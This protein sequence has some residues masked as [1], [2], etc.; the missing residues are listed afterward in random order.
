MS[1]DDFDS[2]DFGSDVD[3]ESEDGSD[4]QVEIEN[5][6]Y[7]AKDSK[8]TGQ[9]K[10]ALSNFDL[11]IENE[12]AV[13][14]NYYFKALKQ[15]IK[16]TFTMR[17]FDDMVKRFAKLLRLM[18][19][20]KI[21]QN[22]GE[23]A[24]LKLLD[25]I[26]AAKE[27]EILE[28]MY[29]IT[30][31]HLLQCKNDRLWFKIK[32][33]L[34]KEYFN[35]RDYRRLKLAINELKP[36]CEADAYTDN[37]KACQLLDILALEIQMCSEFEKDNKRL[38]KLCQ[39]AES[40][41][42][43]VAHPFVYGIIKECTAK[44]DLREGRY[45]DAFS[46][47]FEAFKAFSE[48]SSSKDA[49]INCLKYVLMTAMLMKSDINPFN[50]QEAKAYQKNPDIQPMVNLLESYQ[51]RDLSKFQSILYKFKTKLLNDSIIKENIERM[52]TDLRVAVL[53]KIIRPYSIIKIA[54]LAGQLNM[55]ADEAEL[56]ISHCIMDRTISGRIDQI[57][58]VLDLDQES[59]K[60]KDLRSEAMMS[61]AKRLE[62]LNCKILDK[63]HC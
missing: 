54:S 36:Y 53:Q 42:S 4:G 27:V 56:L 46:N 58:G 5:L 20:R 22:D 50:A 63:V 59:R 1:D 47:F 30:F 61:W 40:L 44:T 35:R 11:I 39:Q 33:K 21:S 13:S 24:T 16:L 15:S 25:M 2:C 38:K 9:F 60:S 48:T 41:T 23:Q 3:Y 10:E 7:Q 45:E 28:K 32:L 55:E 17:S 8:S 31:D 19:S 51:S 34:A 6:Y 43:A 18:S 37:V 29:G 52:L 49:V 62:D 26:G 57:N 14:N 12:E